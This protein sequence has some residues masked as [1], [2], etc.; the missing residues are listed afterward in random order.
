MSAH[1]SIRISSYRPVHPLPFHLH[2]ARLFL[3]D[4]QHILHI[5]E[6]TSGENKIA[7]ERLRNDNSGDAYRRSIKERLTSVKRPGATTLDDAEGY[8]DEY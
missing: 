2:C 8:N 1:E 6:P 7:T 4:P 3:Y 5:D